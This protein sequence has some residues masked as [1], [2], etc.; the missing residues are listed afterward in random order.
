MAF[1][2]TG[3]VA[4][5]VPSP[6]SPV[7]LVIPLPLA[8][9]S[10]NAWLFPGERPALVDCGVGTTEG[11]AA[12]LAGLRAAK[13][14]PAQLR[15]FVTHG[16]IDH[17]GNAAVLHRDHGVEL[18]APREEAPF[19]ETFRRDAARR[20]DAFARALERHGAPPEAVASSRE[21]AGHMDA[22]MEDVPIGKPLRDG[23]RLLLGGVEVT[24]HITPG[25]TPGS[26]VFLT[27]DNDLLSGDTLLEHITSNAIELVD[28]DHGRY[29][30]YLRTL[31][32]LRRFVGAQVLPGHHDPFPLTD[33]LLDGHLEKHNRR[34]AKVLA[35]LDAPRT[36][37]EL[38]PRVLPH[39]AH[40]QV[41]LGMCEMVGHLHMLEIEGKAKVTTD[42]TTG[43]RRF[44]RT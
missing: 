17:A 2:A 31:E 40:D 20:S 24:A 37:W 6:R 7:R 25:H 8:L 16:H 33:A 30:Q 4:W 44:S 5:V 1:S 29:A 41:F 11:R 19:V 27:A 18:Q 3:G 14:D 32:G 15:L 35:A 21:R 39:L 12:L 36:A 38:L 9:K 42:A 34:T 22:W 28:R 13:V 26:T 23:E 10:A 43:V